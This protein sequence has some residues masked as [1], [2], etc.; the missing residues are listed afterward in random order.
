MK[1]LYEMPSVERIVGIIQFQ[2]KVLIATETKVYEHVEEKNSGEAR[3][4]PLKFNKIPSS[5]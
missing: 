2:D 5:Y 4:L 1:L 3:P